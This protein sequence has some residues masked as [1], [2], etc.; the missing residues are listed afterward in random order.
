MEALQEVRDS[1]EEVGWQV[2]RVEEG[3]FSVMDEAVPADQGD[4]ARFLEVLKEARIMEIRLQDPV[5]PELLE[6]FLQR[7]SPSAPTVGLSGA[8][9][10]RGME[11]VL[12]LSFLP[13]PGVALRGM[14]GSVQNLFGL[15]EEESPPRDDALLQDPQDPVAALPPEPGE[16]EPAPEA[17]SA[18]EAPSALEDGDAPQA[19]AAPKVDAAPD[20]LEGQGAP[21]ASSALEELV[22]QFFSAPWALKGELGRRITAEAET[23][24]D[25]RDLP[26]LADLVLL[27]AD[28]GSGVPDSR[29][30]ELARDLLSPAVASHLVARFGGVREE[31]ARARMIRISTALGRE[32]AVA[33]ADALV[34]ARD[35]FQR[36]SYMDAL[37]AQGTLA[38]DVAQNMVEDPR[39]FVV[40]NGVTLMGEIGGEEVVTHLTGSLANSDAR[41][42][43]ETVLA[44][45]KIGGEDAELLLQGMLDDL[46][47]EVRAM[48]CRGV[49]VLKVEKALKRLLKILEE[50]QDEDVQVEC[51][52]ALGKIGDPGA[53][54]LI[55]K[56]AVG[57]MF[58]RPN[59]EVRV[60]AYRALAGIGTPHARELLAKACKDSDPSIRTVV[61]ALLG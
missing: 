37:L 32:M 41:V 15:P 5:E 31:E 35:R 54:P 23:L 40:R 30:V 24:R 12:G 46:E 26:A 10:F 51:L 8:E 45:A 44:L 1:Q 29:G 21:E 28:P 16:E 57:G 17:S 52:Q 19:A 11:E 48:A 38:L 34:E 2:I 50:D 6:A 33:L 3:S 9:R 42:R 43:R 56:R 13:G 14:A 58:S 59:K 7:V 20:A 60:A 49:G 25:V 55:E 4:P 39:W 61:Q 22:E 47:P 53:V 18:G 27:L 36:R